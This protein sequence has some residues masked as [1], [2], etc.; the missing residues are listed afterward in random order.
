M[1]GV[2]VY[3][4][5]GRFLH[6]K[7]MTFLG[8]MYFFGMGFRVVVKGKKASSAEAPILAV[9]PHSSFFD[10]IACIEAGLPSTVSRSESM[11]A[12]IF[13]SKQ[14]G[15]L[16]QYWFLQK[17]IQKANAMPKKCDHVFA[18]E[19]IHIVDQFQC[20][21]IVRVIAQLEGCQLSHIWRETQAIRPK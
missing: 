15:Y 14:C 21:Q 16:H 3:V 11:E 18:F 5:V 2:L 17:G 7:V 6:K 8:Q 10:A 19:Y 13:G 20:G 12:P 1:C 4:F 9:A